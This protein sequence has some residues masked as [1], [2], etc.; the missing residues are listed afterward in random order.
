M[1]AKRIHRVPLTER[2][3]AI[4]EKQRG[5]SK[6]FIF[7]NGKNALSNMALLQ[8]LRRLRPGVTVHGFRSSFRDWAGDETS[9]PREVA[10]GALAH[11]IEDRTEA[12]YRRSDALKRRREL[13]DLW[14]RFLVGDFG[15]V[16]TIAGKRRVIR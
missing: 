13:M 16:V 2:A 1:K 7:P 11:M 8:C 14:D 5:T 6:T 9:F 12:A 3:L 10:E 15:N 4:L